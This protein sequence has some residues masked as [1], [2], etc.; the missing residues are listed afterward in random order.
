MAKRFDTSLRAGEATGAGVLRISDALL[1]YAIARIQ[2]PSRDRDEDIHAVRTTLKHLRALLRMIRPATSE[3]A[4][5]RQNAQW[6]KAARRLGVARDLTV[7]RQSLEELSK[8]VSGKGSRRAFSLV[9]DHY[10]QL[11]ASHPPAQRESAMRAVAA[12]LETSRLRLRRLRIEAADWAVIGPGLEAVYRSA[13]RRMKKAFADGSDEAFHRWRIRVKNL[14]YELQTLSPAWPRRLARTLRQLAIL[15]SKI[16]S[17][18]DL[19]VLK[20]ALR[21]K[22]D[23]FGG[24]AAVKNVLGHL[25]KRSR[26]LRRD[27]RELAAAVFDEKPVRFIRR[28]EQHWIKWKKTPRPPRERMAS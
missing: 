25:Q 4:F 21:A 22:P 7:G 14:F 5:Q 10:G 6:K 9:Q 27:S 17:D 8:A 12:T 28:L 15:Q 11:A 13:R 20:A 23:Q 18:H 19:I 24:K 16:G 26:K 1:K 2:H 3:T